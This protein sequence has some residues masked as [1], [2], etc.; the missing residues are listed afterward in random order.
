M[1]GGRPGHCPADSSG[2][3]GCGTSAP[4]PSSSSLPGPELRSPK[5]TA[6]VRARQEGLTP[7]PHPH[8]HPSLSPGSCQARSP[9]WAGCAGPG[10]RALG[11]VARWSLERYRARGTRHLDVPR[12]GTCW[13]HCVFAAQCTSPMQA[14]SAALP[15]SWGGGSWGLAQRSFRPLQGPPGSAGLTSAC[16]CSLPTLGLGLGAEQVR[17]RTTGMTVC[18]L[19]HELPLL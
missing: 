11:R 19:G 14:P 4:G 10:W 13:H 12:S 1:A 5:L 16:P 8:P 2:S 6:V 17:I 9:A 18:C 3:S 15:P 7:H